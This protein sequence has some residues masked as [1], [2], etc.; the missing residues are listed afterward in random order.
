MTD[1]APQG[2]SDAD[3]EFF[4]DL[5]RTKLAQAPAAGCA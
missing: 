1:T 4:R 5:A 2:V 3:I